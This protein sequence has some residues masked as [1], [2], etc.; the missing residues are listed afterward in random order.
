MTIYLY[1]QM[2]PTLLPEIK[3]IASL[4]ATVLICRIRLGPLGGSEHPIIRIPKPDEIAR[5]EVV[6]VESSI[7]LFPFPKH[8]VSP[9]RKISGNL[10]ACQSLI[11]DI[12]FPLGN[13]QVK[14][15]PNDQ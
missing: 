3:D 12:Q 11:Q 13:H 4:F 9:I 5:P 1:D 2:L 14:L 8:A 6:W 10:L 7:I 15:T